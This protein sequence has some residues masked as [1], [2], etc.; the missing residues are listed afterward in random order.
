LV[1]DADGNTATVTVDDAGKPFRVTSASA[2]RGYEP[3][4]GATGI[5]SFAR[6][7]SLSRGRS[8]C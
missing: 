1:K 6:S 3:V 5:T 4:Y 2:S 7:R 8:D